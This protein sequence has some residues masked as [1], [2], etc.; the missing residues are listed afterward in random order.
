[1]K[2]TAAPR[3]KGG[4]DMKKLLRVWRWLTSGYDTTIISDQG[5]I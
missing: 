5:I 2:A 3:C 1:M 4:G